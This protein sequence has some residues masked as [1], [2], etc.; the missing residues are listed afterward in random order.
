MLFREKIRFGAPPLARRHNR[1]LQAIFR[2]APDLRYDS[3]AL[4]FQCSFQKREIFA[5]AGLFLDL[6]GKRK[7]R[8]IVFGDDQ[9]SGSILI[10]AVHDAGAYL[11]VDSAQR[12][13]AK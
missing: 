5:A 4:L 7:V 8:T 12:I 3:S 1:H 2:I 9:K 11:P 10:D 6:F 13:Q